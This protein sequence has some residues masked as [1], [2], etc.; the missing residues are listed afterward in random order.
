MKQRSVWKRECLVP[1][2]WT[3]A[4]DLH[5][6]SNGWGANHAAL[7]DDKNDNWPV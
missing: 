7:N 3:S 6:G 2:L 5:R 4:E 1:F